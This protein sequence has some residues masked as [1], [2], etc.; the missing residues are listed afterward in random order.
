MKIKIKFSSNTFESFLKE[1]LS[2]G[3][4]A[5][6]H[7]TIHNQLHL[8][9]PRNKSKIRKRLYYWLSTKVDKETNNE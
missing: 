5:W 1:I 7:N 6:E 2:D 9:L 3:T 8:D 4:I